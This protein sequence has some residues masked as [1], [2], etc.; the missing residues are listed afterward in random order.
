MLAEQKTKRTRGS[1]YNSIS[2]MRVSDG[3]RVTAY[4]IATVWVANKLYRSVPRWFRN[5]KASDEDKDA[6]D[7]LADPLV[8]LKKI[9]YMMQLCSEE[10]DDDLPW[11]KL[12]ACFLTYLHFQKE[13]RKAHP[14]H[15]DL[16]YREGNSSMDDVASSNN[17]NSNYKKH[18]KIS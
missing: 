15:K 12:H 4:V 17:N 9:R 5:K 6:N 11:Y 13:L 1:K 8:I 14:T 3:A 16:R 18:I 10:V 7:D 2:S